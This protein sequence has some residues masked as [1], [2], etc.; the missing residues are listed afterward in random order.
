[1]AVERLGGVY[2]VVVQGLVLDLG[3]HDDREKKINFG[4]GEQKTIAE[5]GKGVYICPISILWLVTQRLSVLC[6]DNKCFL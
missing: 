2:T 4:P 3:F 6:P 5:S 1:M